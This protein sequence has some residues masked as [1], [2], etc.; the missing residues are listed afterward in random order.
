[1]DCGVSPKAL[2]LDLLRVAAPRAI[3]VR[4]FVEIGALF[5]LT[6]NAVRVAVTRLVGAGLVES[7]ERGSYRLT[8]AAAPLSAHVEAWRLGEN[9]MRAWSGDWLAVSLA[10]IASRTARRRS[11]RALARLGYRAAMDGVWLRPDNL[12]EPRAAMNAKLAELGLE[13]G[14]RHFIARDF[15]HDLVARWSVELWHSESTASAQRAMHERLEVSRKKVAKMPVGPAAVET[16]LLG[17]AAIRLL[18][19]DPLLPPEIAD[20]AARAALTAAMLEYDR[21]GR[22]VWTALGSEA[23]ERSAPVHVV[24]AGALS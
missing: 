9:R 8:A 7:D 13:G 2:V 21:V 12:A 19:T 16:F 24:H 1:M 23:V 4:S 6:G 17:G 14:A 18:S 5:G 22:A 11:E 20:S 15:E 3:P 10:P